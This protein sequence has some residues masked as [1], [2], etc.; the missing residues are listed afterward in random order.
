MSLAVVLLKVCDCYSDKKG[1]EVWGEGRDQLINI[2]TDFWVL[3]V[4]TSVSLA[5][6]A[7][8]NF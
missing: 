4:Q 3:V 6:P 8:I 1:A 2:T 7:V 5:F